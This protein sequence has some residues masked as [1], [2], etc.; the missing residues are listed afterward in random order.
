MVSKENLL[1]LGFFAMVILFSFEVAARDLGEISSISTNA[2]G[3][4]G[5]DA[6]CLGGGGM[7]GGWGGIGGGMG[8]GDMGGGMGGGMGGRMP[9]GGMGG[10]MGGGIVGSAKVVNEQ[11]DRGDVKYDKKTNDGGCAGDHA[12]CGGWGGGMGGGGMGGGMGGGGMGGGGMGGAGMGGGGMGGGMPGGGMG[13]GMGGGIASSA[14]VINEQKDRGDV[15][16]DK[17][18]NIGGCAGDHS[19]CG[20]WGGGMGGG[21]MGGGGMGGGGMG[22]GDMGGGGMGGG[23]YGGGIYWKW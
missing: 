10:G 5:D 19:N 16:Y 18:T 8:G 23:G 13:G 11:N 14:K 15:K 7:G 6:N 22:G 2:G 4:V 9:G 17:N 20:G 3:C 12:N 1:L 21:G